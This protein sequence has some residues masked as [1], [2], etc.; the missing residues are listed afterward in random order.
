[1]TGAMHRTARRAAAFGLVVCGFFPALPARAD[2]ARALMQ[3]VHDQSRQHP[4]QR[5]DVKMLIKDKKGRTRTRYFN[6]LYKI[7]PGRS[8]SLVKIYRPPSVRDTGLLSESPDGARTSDQWIYLPALQSVKKLNT[9][10]KHKSFMGSDFTN[11]DIAGRQV[12]QD[13]HRIAARAGGL[14]TVLSTPKDAGEPYAKIETQILDRIKVPRRVIFYDRAGEKLKTLENET[15]KKV[16]GMYVVMRARMI[17]HQT[18]GQSRVEKSRFTVGDP[19]A[20]AEV[21]FRGLRE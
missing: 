7:F 12:D 5:A 11:A 20:S 8:K 1:M 6:H 14:I 3:A 2:E 4:D 18:G 16:K 13:R 17:N 15:I 19:I 21:G 10:D 9:R